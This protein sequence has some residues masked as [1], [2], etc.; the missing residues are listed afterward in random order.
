MQ[1]IKQWDKLWTKRNL[2]NS[3][4][5]LFLKEKNYLV[6]G[7]KLVTGRSIHYI[8]IQVWLHMWSNNARTVIVK[9]LTTD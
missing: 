1:F 9:V 4:L 2:K 8:S 3:G 5:T 7:M 6:T